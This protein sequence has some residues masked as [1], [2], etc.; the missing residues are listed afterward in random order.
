MKKPGWILLASMI[1]LILLA[2]C[3]LSNLLTRTTDQ[4]PPTEITF[5]NWDGDID[6][7]IFVAFEAQS[8]IKIKFVPYDNQEDAVFEIQNGASYDVVVLENQWIPSLVQEGL[9]AEINY[10]NVPN[11]KY[12]SANFRDLSYD[13]RNQHAIPYSWGTTGLVVRTDLVEEPVTSWAALWD[14]RYANKV[15]GWSIPR[16]MIGIALKSLG[17]SLNTQDPQQLQAAEEQLMKLK[18]K[19]KLVDWEPAVSA[20]LLVSGEVVI[21]VGQADDVLEGHEQ[22]KDIQYIFPEE[23]GLLWGDNFTILANSPHKAVAEQFINFLLSPEISA[24]IINETYYMLPNDATM[25]L[26]NTDIRNNP[27]IYPSQANLVNTEIILPL[28]AA[29]EQRYYEIWDHFIQP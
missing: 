24:Q 5:R 23:G 17:Y 14:P 12:I 3:Q 20:P 29:T 18:G 22:N 19:I 16:Y 6:Q 9:L 10:N 8:G 26:V 25:P 15:I 13:P 11:F 21:A 1:C 27:A 4:S 7:N 2:G 28:S